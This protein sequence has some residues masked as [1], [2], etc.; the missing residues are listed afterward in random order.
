MGV[1]SLWCQ[2]ASE[3]QENSLMCKSVASTM[4]RIE[5]SR[6]TTF[7][8]SGFLHALQQ[9]VTS[10]VDPHFDFNSQQDAAYILGIILDELKGTSPIADELFSISCESCVVCNKCSLISTT[11]EKLDMLPLVPNKN[12][13]DS[14]NKFFEVESLDGNN[15]YN[16]PL[17]NSLQE[18]TIQKQISRCGNVLIVHLKRFNN[19]HQNTFKDCSYFN[20][21]PSNSSSISIPISVDGVVSFRRTFSLIA[22]INHSGRFEQG[23]YWAYTKHGSIWYECNDTSV[24][25]VKSNKINNTSSYVLIFA[26]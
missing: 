22:T 2:A 9:T 17:C 13:S 1:P 24:A 25:E 3:G 7:D 18:A 5:R 20:C 23:H 15:K 19:I 14:L 21:L 8:P 26:A 4:S 16:C 6:A 12:I 11:E 10:S